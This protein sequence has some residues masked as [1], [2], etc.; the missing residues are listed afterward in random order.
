MGAR[1]RF[2]QGD[3]I[4]P[5]HS[6][7]Y[8]NS[9]AD[10]LSIF[11]VRGEKPTEG[12]DLGII[13]SSIIWVQNDTGL[14]LERYWPVKAY[15]SVFVDQLN[16]DEFQNDPF[17]FN[18][19]LPD[20]GIVDN[21]GVMLEPAEPGEI[22]LAQFAGWVQCLVNMQD[23]SHRHA[24]PNGTD[25]DKLQSSTS[26]LPLIPSKA[27]TGDVWCAVRLGGGGGGGGALFEGYTTTAVDGN[28]FDVENINV[29]FGQYADTETSLGAVINR[30]G[31]VIEQGGW[32]VVAVDASNNEL[33]AIQAECPPAPAYMIWKDTW[34]DA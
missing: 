5:M 16:D 25:Q 1:K 28:N 17:A 3:S 12:E 30:P 15:G 29:I 21:L 6:A 26:G 34:T 18:A 27:G 32:V 22:R 10:M 33:I 2:S 19:G 14:S 24:L 11:N 9:I 23:E 8:H 31:W 13:S 4:R 20:D 7:S